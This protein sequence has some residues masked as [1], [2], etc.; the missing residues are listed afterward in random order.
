[1]PPP[2]PRVRLARLAWETA[3]A[4]KGIAAGSVGARSQ[5]ATNDRGE[6]LPGVL[7]AAR[8]DGS[9]DVELHLVARW[10]VPPLHELGER[11]HDRVVAAAERQGLGESLGELRISFGDLLDAGEPVMS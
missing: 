7:A 6:L 9:Y 10:P 4:T 8:R 11:I 3:L 5:W 2:T 1:V